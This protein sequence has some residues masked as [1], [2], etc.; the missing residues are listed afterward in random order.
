MAD[1]EAILRKPYHRVIVPDDGE[2]TGQII[3]F[4]GCIAIGKSV[5][6]C[7]TSLEEVALEWLDASLEQGHV[8]PD[9]I[10]DAVSEVRRTH[11]LGFRATLSADV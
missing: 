1:L 2:F 4:P 9:P 6:E 5:A 3:E 11:G 7:A 8:I 10:E